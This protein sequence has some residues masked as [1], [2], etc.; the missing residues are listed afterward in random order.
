[1]GFWSVFLWINCAKFCKLLVFRKPPLIMR[2]SFSFI[3]SEEND[4]NNT[5]SCAG[6][7]SIQ[8][9][10]STIQKAFHNAFLTE[11][12]IPHHAI[13]MSLFCILWI[14][15]CLSSQQIVH[16]AHP[17]YPLS[18]SLIECN[19]AQYLYSFMFHYESTTIFLLMSVWIEVLTVILELV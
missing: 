12:A 16:W 19:H 13:N 4:K 10:W 9:S 15:A 18:K 2:L 7:K 11:N 14:S 6:N 8:I 1:M 5:F 17:T 3:W